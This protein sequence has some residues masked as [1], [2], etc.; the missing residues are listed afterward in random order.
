M[1]ACLFNSSA[2]LLDVM[3]GS[4]DTFYSCTLIFT[5]L[6]LIILSLHPKVCATCENIPSQHYWDFASTIE[7][8]TDN[9]FIAG[10]SWEW[11]FIVPFSLANKELNILSYSSSGHG[12]SSRESWTHPFRGNLKL[13][14]W[15][16]TAQGINYVEPHCQ[17]R[18]SVRHNPSDC[19]QGKKRRNNCSKSRP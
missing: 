9:E 6:A 8:P 14:W 4:P 15:N 5:H 18:F 3:R 16:S 12:V 11:T 2:S 7:E 10:V 1:I 13:R 19:L 17:L